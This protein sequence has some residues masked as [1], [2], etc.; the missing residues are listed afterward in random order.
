MES[1]PARNRV[2]RCGAREKRSDVDSEPPDKPSEKID[3]DL[4]QELIKL[5]FEKAKGF[6]KSLSPPRPLSMQIRPQGHRVVRARVLSVVLS[7]ILT[8]ISLANCYLNIPAGWIYAVAAIF[9]GFSVPTLA[10]A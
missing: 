3:P 9:A 6:Q 10:A 8:A 7:A 1:I 5:S 4:I 2:G